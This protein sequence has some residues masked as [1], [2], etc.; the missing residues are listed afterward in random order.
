V[1]AARLRRLF[2]WTLVASL[3]L[4]AAIAI[5]TLLFA[6]FDDRAGRILGTTALLAL[7]SLLA[8]PAGVLLDQ[9]RARALAWGQLAVVVAGFAFADYAVWSD[10]DP[11]W[12]WK[13]PVTLGGLAAAGAQAAASTSRREAGDGRRIRVLYWVAIA[14]S[15]ALAVLVAFA[16][17]KEIEAEDYYR[18]LGAT[19]VAALLA[20]LLQPLLRRAGR[21]AERPLRLVL[22]LDREAPPEAVAAVVEVL[23]RYG[24]RAKGVVKSQV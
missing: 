15:V 18:F 3:C 1:Q 21:P 23:A 9:G 11:E 19:A 5:G 12:V 13:L 17:W 6:E 20:S 8:M 7:A 14:L 2:L 4:T 10:A 22:E 24:V 16:A